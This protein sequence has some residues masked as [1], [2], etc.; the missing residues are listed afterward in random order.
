MTSRTRDF[1]HPAAFYL[2]TALVHGEADCK[3]ITPTK[4]QLPL[5]HYHCFFDAP[6]PCA[7]CVFRLPAVFHDPL[8]DE[9]SLPQEYMGTHRVRSW[10]SQSSPQSGHA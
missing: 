6:C 5:P 2:A 4:P 8:I 9:G 7:P 3:V 10:S 1:A